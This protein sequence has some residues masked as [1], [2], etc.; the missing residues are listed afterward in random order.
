MAP[1]HAGGYD[2]D[3]DDKSN[4]EFEREARTTLTDAAVDALNNK[5]LISALFLT[6][7]VPAIIEPP[8][9][10][11]DDY[12]GAAF[13]IF[14]LSAALAIASGFYCILTAV[15]IGDM[16]LIFAKDM[17]CLMVLNHNVFMLQGL[18]TS[19]QVAA[20]CASYVD[21]SHWSFWVAVAFCAISLVA[22]GTLSDLVNLNLVT[23]RSDT[24]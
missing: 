13:L 11:K 4:A 24:V 16:A 2:S 1:P 8:E 21:S 14:F 15:F 23:P 7:N 19:I 17:A 22:T 6:F 12:E 5:A 20:A 18:A 9:H 10:M 3:Y